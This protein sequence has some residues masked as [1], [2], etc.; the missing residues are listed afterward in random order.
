L[1]NKK[2]RQ[3]KNNLELSTEENGFKMSQDELEELAQ[4]KSSDKSSGK[5]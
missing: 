4:D 2:V 3:R 5:G 1:S